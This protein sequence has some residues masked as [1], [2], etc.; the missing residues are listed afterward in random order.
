[1]GETT[2]NQPVLKNSKDQQSPLI[3]P[4]STG[5]RIVYGLATIALPIISFLISFEFPFEGPEWQD[6]NF[7]SY[8]QLM[9]GGP[10]SYYF[11]PL[12]LFSMICMG[13]LLFKPDVGKKFTVRLGIY[14]GVIFSFHYSILILATGAFWIVVAASAIWLIVIPILIR[15]IKAI[16]S[17]KLLAHP[18]K[19]TISY[20]VGI[21]I[22]IVMI[23]FYNDIL[24]I[25]SILPF[26]L[27]PA[28]PVICFF[29][30]IKFSIRLFRRFEIP[31]TISVF[32]QLAVVSWI[33]AYLVAWRFSILKAIEM[34]A[35]LPT[36]PPDCYI[37]TAAAKGHPTIVRS[38]PVNLAN[39]AVMQVNTQ[40]QILKAAEI[41]LK[42]VAPKIYR[43]CRIFYDRYGQILARTLNSPSRGT[44][45]YIGLKPF[46]CAAQ[47]V[48]Q[49]LIPDSKNISKKLYMP[50]HR[51]DNS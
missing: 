13:Y 49:F 6:G 23:F 24:G 48:F 5:M 8:L 39:G 32:H 45:A 47:I 30:S 34:Y 37:A 51:R 50:Y 4:E 14:T 16:W 20:S 35:Q 42:T 28:G 7:S 15:G 21:G 33:G 18:W 41:A 25:I 40:L 17:N 29:I 10:A 27:L 2:H 46:E 11:Y 3:V 36:S 1:M 43:R 26:S 19:N 9:T 38:Q 31:T 12:L 44:L 22:L